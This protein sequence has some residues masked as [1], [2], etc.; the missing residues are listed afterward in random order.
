MSTSGARD[1]ALISQVRATHAHHV[2][3]VAVDP[4][5]SITDEILIQAIACSTGDVHE[6]GERPETSTKAT[7]LDTNDTLIIQKISRKVVLALTGFANN[8]GEF[9][10]YV[11]PCPANTLSKSIALLSILPNVGDKSFV[12]KLDMLC[13][14]VKVILDVT[15]CMAE[16]MNILQFYYI[17]EGQ[18]AV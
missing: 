8:F 13:H 10:Y 6:P 4:L 11:Q 5:I 3:E 2:R 12:L 16:V 18:L 14:L 17:S 9:S 1:D 15:K 7:Q